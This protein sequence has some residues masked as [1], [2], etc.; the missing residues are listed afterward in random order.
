[1]ARLRNGLSRWLDQAREAGLETEDVEALFASVI[2][3]NATRRTQE[4]VA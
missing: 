2:V 3:E 4:G 1:M